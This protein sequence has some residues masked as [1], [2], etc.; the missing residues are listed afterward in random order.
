MTDKGKEAES[1]LMKI[2]DKE[3]EI[4]GKKLEI[5]ALQ[6]K[7]S[8]VTAIRYDKD[9]VQT[10]PKNYMEMA[11]ADIEE[12]EL[13]LEEDKASIEEVKGTAYSIVRRMSDPE[14]RALI[15]WYYLN[16]LSMPDVIDKMYRSERATY[17]LRD[18][19]LESFGIILC[20]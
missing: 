17:Y 3:K 16:G 5:E 7:A 15:E 10:S 20:E 13:E 19:A 8:G 4:R 12:L 6:W 9:K 1:Y 18:D 14:Q 2:R 11:I